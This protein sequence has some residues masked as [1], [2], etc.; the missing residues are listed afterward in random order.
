[1]SKKVVNNPGELTEV[2]LDNP[3]KGTQTSSLRKNPQKVIAGL[4]G[5]NTKLKNELEQTKK[6]LSKQTN[7]DS[8]MSSRTTGRVWQG[9]KNCP[10]CRNRYGYQWRFYRRW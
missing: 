4:K 2:A 7:E 8:T 1:M 5:Y 3:D 6:K 9:L 10:G